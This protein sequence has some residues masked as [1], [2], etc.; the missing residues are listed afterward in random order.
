MKE[1]S[2]HLLLSLPLDEEKQGGKNEGEKIPNTIVEIHNSKSY[3][4][5]AYYPF[6][7]IL[8]E[9]LLNIRKIKLL[10]GRNSCLMSFPSTD[11]GGVKFF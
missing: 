1:A 9:G 5:L 10:Q 11:R 7:L 2:T 3:R 4:G 6:P 8:V